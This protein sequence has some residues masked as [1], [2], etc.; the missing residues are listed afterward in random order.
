MNDYRGL[1]KAYHEHLS[2][3]PNERLYLGLTHNLG[4]LPDPSLEEVAL[5]VSH[6]RHLLA[7]LT[8]V[9]K[10]NLSF[11][12]RLDLD[13]M[14]LTLE[15]QIH[16]KTLRF[17]GKSMAEQC[18]VAGQQIGDGLF[19][20]MVNDPRPPTIRL[21][22]I[23]ERIEKIPGYLD[24]LLERL[25]TPV[26]R[27]VSMEKEQLQGLRGLFDTLEQWA[28]EEAWSGLSRLRAARATAQLAIEEYLS[29]LGDL[30]TTQSFH[31]GEAEARRVVQLRGIEMSIEELHVHAKRFLARNQETLNALRIRLIDK[32]DLCESTTIE[33]LHEFLNKRFSVNVSNDRLEDILDIYKAENDKIVAFISEHDLFDIFEDQDIKIIRTPQFLATS[34][35]AGAMMSPPPFRDGTKTSLVYL[36]LSE[37]LLDEHTHLGIP[38]MMIHEGIPGHHLQLANA[39]LHPSIV[40][41]H[42]EA[43]EHAEGWTT[44]LED[45]MLDVG[46]MGDLTDEARFIGKL[47]IN[48]IGARVAID[49]F[50][51]TG[52]RDYL[53]VTPVELDFSSDDPFE[54]AGTLL[55]AVT[56][57]TNERTQAELNWYSQERGYPLS[58]LTG[59]VLVWEL[60]QDMMTN[61]TDDCDERHL[62]RVFHRLYLQSGNMPVSYLR[63]VAEH[64]GLLD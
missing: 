18:P 43:M 4:G 19:V 8:D 56:G 27:W 46:Y 1:L 41:R 5:S 63:R 35:P 45:Y 49:L 31:I 60:K 24:A 33:Q 50:F 2:R 37:E 64:E 44:M 36:T 3:C 17:N 28:V 7:M 10:G 55:Q 48:R 54:L 39:A 22:L 34:I 61:Q 11:D 20:L 9:D 47:D 15:R 29:G 12:D 59:N 51:M 62:D 30:P 40:R 26:A 13:L 38:G 42:F 52:D 21:G 58:Y 6:A 57:F 23:V 32:Y 16:D 53:K 14:R 25:N